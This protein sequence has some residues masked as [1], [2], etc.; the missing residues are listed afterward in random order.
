MAVIT[1]NGQGFNP[2]EMKI[3]QSP[4][5]APDAGRDQDAYMFPNKI[6]DKWKISLSFWNPT[7]AETARILSAVKPETVNVQFTN[8]LTNSLQTIQ[9][10]SGD[11]TMDVKW[12]RTNNKRYG[13][14][15]FNLIER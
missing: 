7:P 2:S 14:V 11:K 15:S 1:I 9:C 8:P 5:S 6:T 12:W 3:T 13:K 10:Y 4:V